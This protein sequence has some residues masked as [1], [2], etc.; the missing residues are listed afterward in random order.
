MMRS[1]GGGS[2]RVVVVV[3]SIGDLE[4]MGGEIMHDAH[5]GN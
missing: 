2:G 3:A 4:S 1:G 5:K